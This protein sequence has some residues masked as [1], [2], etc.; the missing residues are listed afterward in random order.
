M[1]NLTG[2]F[3]LNTNIVYGDKSVTHRAFI[4]AALADGKSVIHNVTLS[5]DI[6]AT[7]HCLRTLGAKI[8]FNGI[9]ATVEPIS[10]IPKGTLTLN[11]GNSGTTARLLAGVVAGLG[12][13]AKFVGDES[14]AKRPMQRVTEPLRLL[15]ASIA[16]DDGCL[17]VTQGGKLCGTTISAQVNSA[18][19]KS[20]VLLAG[21]FATGETRYIEQLPTRNHTELML[22][23]LGAN[24]AVD[25][26]EIT[27]SKSTLKPFEV[28]IP[29]DPSGAAFGVALAVAKG[30]EVTFPNVL[31]NETRLG[32]YR[33]LQRSGANISFCNVREV[34]GERVGDIVVKKSVLKPFI[35]SEQDVCDGIDEVALLATLALTVKGKHKFTNIAELQYKECN[36]VQAIEHIAAICNQKTV[37]DGKDLTVTSNGKLPCGQHFTS[38]G[39]HRIA[40]CETVLSL[41]VGGGSVD[42]TP[43]AVSFPNFTEMLGITPLKLGLIGE[44]VT[45]SKSPQLMSCL[46]GRANVCCSYDAINLPKDITDDNLLKVIESYDGLNVTMPF[47]NKVAK[48]LNAE[49]PSV[50][51]V[52]NNI[53]P[54]STDGY[55]IIQ[56]LL[57]HNIDIVN[58]PLWIVGA[59]GAA[60][61]AVIE[62]LKYGCKLQIINRTESH[63]KALTEKHCLQN[64]VEN[65]IGV[66]SFVPSCVFEQSLTLPQSCEFVLVAAYKGYSGLR[67]QATNRRLTV[68]D[69]L[70]MLYHQ[71]AKS[72]S[73]WTNTPIQ[74][75]YQTFARTK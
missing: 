47:K 1:I 39:D 36:R 29:N 17:F 45:D 3:N 62:L 30:I 19:V 69:G 65:P 61:A 9:T 53:E 52:G 24:I 37:F 43:Y 27:V 41:I 35:A 8:E 10:N 18:Q 26:N 72:F 44:S 34:F 54:Q 64:A 74:K 32:F 55:G 75:D 68:I 40:M 48:L 20:A 59:G 56:S 42:S 70:E 50:N 66:L 46:A 15:G 49:C 21:L 57:S 22:R 58:K 31:L 51:T 13:K 5:D 11:C 4:L 7:I 60:E 12:V 73:L 38:F 23:F 2:Q 28:A 16:S 25:G 63:A 71:G 14:L 6:C 67:E 33:V